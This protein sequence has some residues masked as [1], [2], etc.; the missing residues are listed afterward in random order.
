V[1]KLTKERE[2]EK[3]AIIYEKVTWLETLVIVRKDSF[4]MG[5]YVAKLLA[6]I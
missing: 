5:M 3:E 4:V 6:L 2:N 1:P